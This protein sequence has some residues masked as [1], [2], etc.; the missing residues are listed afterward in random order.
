L[1]NFIK[2]KKNDKDKKGTH[3]EEIEHQ[4]TELLQPDKQFYNITLEKVVEEL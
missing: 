2:N 4:N 3:Q 1:E